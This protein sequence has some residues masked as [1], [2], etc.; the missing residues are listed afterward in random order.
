MLNKIKFVYKNAPAKKLLILFSS[1]SILLGVGIMSI[2]VT[3]SNNY[4]QLFTQ[5]ADKLLQHTEHTPLTNSDLLNLFQIEHLTKQSITHHFFTPKFIQHENQQHLLFVFILWFI[6]SLSMF[7]LMTAYLYRFYQKIDSLNQFTLN[8]TLDKPP[9]DI[10]TY[11]EGSFAQLENNLYQKVTYLHTQ[12]TKHKQHKEYLSDNIANISHQLKTPLTALGILTDTLLLD[13]VDNRTDDK[14]KAFNPQLE[15]IE[16]LVQSL[17]LLTK[18]DAGVLPI[19]QET[20][21]LQPILNTLK[22]QFEI[23]LTHN[24]ITFDMETTDSVFIGDTFLITEAISN[25]IK[26]ACDHTPI[27]GK[28]HITIEDS[29]FFSTLKIFNTGQQIDKTDLPHLFERFYKGKNATKTSIGI[30][31]SLAYE[32]VQ[33]HKGKITVENVPIGVLFTINIPK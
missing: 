8:I 16:N 25:L 5:F 14:L 29:V 26:N 32:I 31:L 24:Q 23:L 17:L 3:I 9:F 19:K 30:G 12:A 1:L 13:T 15:K 4:T 11:Q 7:Y 21:A 10:T 18:L 20:I 33:L 28:I 6:F 27:G 2:T 22:Q